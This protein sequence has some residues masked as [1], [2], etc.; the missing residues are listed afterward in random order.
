VGAEKDSNVQQRGAGSWHSYATVTAI[1]FG[2]GGLTPKTMPAGFLSRWTARTR[3][4]DLGR[5]VLKAGGASLEDRQRAREIVIAHGHTSQAHL[6]LLEDKSYFFTPGGSLIAY[7]VCGRT[8]VTLGD[9]IGPLVDAEPAIYRFVHYC[10][11]NRWKAVFTH[12]ESDYL[13]LYRQAGY[14]SMC[15]G[16]EAVVELERFALN[17]NAHKTLRK[18]FNRFS[19][20]GYS[21]VVCEPP[22][23]ET[24]LRELRGI[25]DEWLGMTRATEKGFFLAR[26]EDA[27]VRQEHV[28][29]V[30]TPL[31]QISA[32]ANLAPEY[33]R[34][35]L[36]I[37]LMRH[38]TVFESGTMDFLF[39][40]LL[41]WARE[42]GYKSFNL[43]LSPLYGI[44]TESGSPPLDRFLHWLYGHAR[45]QNFGGFYAFK[46]KF[47]PQWRPLYMMFPGYSYLL[48]A[49]LAVAKANA[50]EGQTLW[51]YF[52]SHPNRASSGDSR[53]SA[54]LAQSLQEDIAGGNVAE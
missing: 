8:A 5:P 17:G 42:H 22:I 49:G 33:Q 1:A 52:R 21:C 14:V 15:L 9:P 38:R 18:R 25:S 2:E 10:R 46:T 35:G 31:G 53:N 24:V 54:A 23:N 29:V 50:G 32:F 47:R 43:G 30:Y 41:F 36:S 3:A 45:F 4:R 6:A 48:A 19:R 11:E 12:V 28:A 20:Q 44:G 27:Y 7:T 16:H 37:D 39:V 34:G 40:S 26:F 51:A 13:A